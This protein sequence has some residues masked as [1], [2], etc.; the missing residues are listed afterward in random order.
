VAIAH[1]VAWPA[2]VDRA[3]ADAVDGAAG[4]TIDLA[5]DGGVTDSMDLAE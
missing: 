2:A 3:V 4:A 5:V 1:A